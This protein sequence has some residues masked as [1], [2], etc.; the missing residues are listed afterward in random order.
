MVGAG[1]PA[2]A[3]DAAVLRRLV[4]ELLGRNLRVVLGAEVL[5]IGVEVG[6]AVGQR[7]D[8]VD[9]RGDGGAAELEAVLAQPVCSRE[10]S[11]TLALAGSAALALDALARRDAGAPAHGGRQ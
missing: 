9:H 1:R 6:A 10:A 5:G 7:N 2:V 8:V 4:A 11:L 3:A